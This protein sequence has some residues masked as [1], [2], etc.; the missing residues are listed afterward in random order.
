MAGT[1]VE[2]SVRQTWGYDYFSFDDAVACESARAD[3]MGFVA[4]LPERV[5]LDEVQRVPTLFAALKLEVDRR[6]AP[7][8]FLLTGS[9]NVLLAP[10][11]S[12]SLAGR[13][14]MVRL[15]PLAQC[16]LQR[17][18][19]S[20]VAMDWFSGFLNALFGGGFEI[21][22]TERLGRDLCERI[23]AGGYPA[24]LARPPGRRRSN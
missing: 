10:A 14:E 8:R 5:I 13:I 23:V 9:S 15:H 24:A 22:R 6:Q 12:D 2:L 1:R 21:Q 11:L 3:P 16:E 18:S 19:T 7:G 20:V 17:K 4:D